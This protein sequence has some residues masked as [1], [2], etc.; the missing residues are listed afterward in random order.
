MILRMQ[1]K[2][3]R[4]QSMR[5]DDFWKPSLGKCPK[6]GISPSR[7]NA[8]GTPNSFRMCRSALPVAARWASSDDV[9]ICVGLHRVARI[10]GKRG[11]ADEVDG[12]AGLWL[13]LDLANEGHK[14][15]GLFATL[16]EAQAFLD[17]LP[18][19]PTVTV[20]SG[21]GIQA[22]LLFREPWL[23]ETDANARGE[24]ARGRLDRLLP[25]RSRR[26]SAARSMPPR[27]WRRFSAPR[28]DNHKYA[29]KPAVTLQDVH[30]DARY[31][32]SATSSATSPRGSQGRPRE[33]RSGRSYTARGWFSIHGGAPFD[34]FE[35][36]KKNCDAFAPTWS[37]TRT[38]LKTKGWSASEWDLPR[39]STVRVEWSDQEIVDTL[40]AYRRYHKDASNCV[41]I[42]TSA[43]LPPRENRRR[44]LKP[45]KAS[46]TTCRGS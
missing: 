42:T 27:V 35:D 6:A 26:R 3:I 20:L 39:Q 14:K 25:R 23:F 22:H 44:S 33:C 21:G 41:K 5:P 12:I 43:R 24:S 17:S 45:A 15:P 32:P 36:L 40:I 9:Y 7:E 19:R 38:D 10:D 16:D 37:R 2:S 31:N 29:H 4:P 18:L 30:N 46:K 11:E 8:I 28:H 13:D 1:V 34:K